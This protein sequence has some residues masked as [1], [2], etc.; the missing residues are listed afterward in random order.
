MYFPCVPF[1]IAREYESSSNYLR[2]FHAFLK[3]DLQ[4]R[5]GNT[6]WARKN[7]N[8]RSEQGSSGNNFLNNVS[9][10]E[11]STA[12]TAI[13]SHKYCHEQ[14]AISMS[15]L[16]LLFRTRA[17]LT[18]ISTPHTGARAAYATATKPPPRSGNVIPTLKQVSLCI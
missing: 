18:N 10:R 8:T 6:S 3:L 9:R 4:S 17:P 16:R 1:S 13:T 7:I 14:I 5:A 15:L 12:T 11:A 2:D